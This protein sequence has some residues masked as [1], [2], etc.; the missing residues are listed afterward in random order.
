MAK[1]VLRNVMVASFRRSE[2]TAG[3]VTKQPALA[4]VA[5]TPSSGG[6]Q[7]T[8]PPALPGSGRGTTV[9]KHADDRHS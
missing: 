5:I 6:Q 4:H 2:I 8:I 9:I 7:L 3:N 1:N